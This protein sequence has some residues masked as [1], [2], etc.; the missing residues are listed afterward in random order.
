MAAL[1]TTTASVRAVASAVVVAKGGA[2][3]VSA[4]VWTVA[5]APGTATF[6]VTT[7]SAG[8]VVLGATLAAAAGALAAS[9]AGGT[10]AAGAAAATADVTAGS[11]GAAN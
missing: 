8:E 3:A 5:A 11:G 7:G 9:A 4:G 1:G 2:L 6:G 10:V